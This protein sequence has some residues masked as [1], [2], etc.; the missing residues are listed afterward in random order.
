MNG[1]PREWA[2]LD[3]LGNVI[4]VIRYRRSKGTRCEY[5]LAFYHSKLK[6]GMHIRNKINTPMCHLRVP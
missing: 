5:V 3:F 6:V 2:G 4:R 1:N